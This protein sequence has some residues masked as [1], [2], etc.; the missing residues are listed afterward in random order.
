MGVLPAGLVHGVVNTFF[1]VVVKRILD[2]L[3]Y[4]LPENQGEAEYGSITDAT[5]NPLVSS[6]NSR[7]TGRGA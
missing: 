2:G 5:Y 3:I 4:R 7:K 6:Q 1:P